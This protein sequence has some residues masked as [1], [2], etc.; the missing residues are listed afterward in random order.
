MNIIFFDPL[1]MFL[2]EFVRG[3]DACVRDQGLPCLDPAPFLIDR[4]ILL[5]GPR[6]EAAPPVLQLVVREMISDGRGQELAH[7]GDRHD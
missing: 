4:T 2:S 1:Q 3:S 7:N 5:P 6:S